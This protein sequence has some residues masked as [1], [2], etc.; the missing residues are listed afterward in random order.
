MKDRKTSRLERPMQVQAPGEKSGKILN[1][2]IQAKIGQ[3][4]RAVYNDVVDQG[5]P[6]RFAEL[7]RRLDD[8]PG[9]QQVGDDH[10]QINKET[11]E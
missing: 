11:L 10:P 1:R 8:D 2:E 4:L 3:Q 7:L 6:D 5:V 9:A